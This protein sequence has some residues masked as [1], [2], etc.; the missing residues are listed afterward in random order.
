MNILI[1][2]GSTTNKG[3]YLMLLAA[4]KLG[5]TYFE[6]ANF[7]LPSSVTD[8]EDLKKEGFKF[9]NHPLFHVGH[10][11]WFK[12]GMKYPLFTNLLFKYG[13][14]QSLSGNVKLKDINLVL[15]VSGFAFGDKF[16]KMPLNNLNT[17][18]AFFKEKRIPYVML[19]QA[20]GPFSGDLKKIAKEAFQDADLIF[21]RDN[22][23][24]QN[25]KSLN[26][27]SNK[28]KQASDIT[29]S[30]NT[31][32]KLP[33]RFS[34][35]KPFCSI[36]PNVRMLDK[37]DESWKNNY[38]RAIKNAV[39]TILNNSDFNVLILVHSTT[40]GGDATLA[41]QI[42]ANF[43]DNKRV[44]LDT[45]ENPLVLKKILKDSELLIGSRFHALA[46]ALSSSTPSIATSWLHKYEMLFADYNIKNYSYNKYNETFE[47][48]ILQLL[49][50]NELA[51]VKE[52]LV[53]KNKEIKIANKNLWQLVA[54]TV[55]S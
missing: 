9:L 43:K 14:G 30:L 3:A 38:E 12:L 39:D 54:D 23:S 32:E 50:K 22:I 44:K 40:I 21:A 45:D 15:D 47:Q 6:K 20:L 34:S 31:E 46:S 4:K 5:T 11:R 52:K 36:V 24:Y 7:V 28:C 19:P 10:D 49:N 48:G 41:E 8:K 18:I 26:L 2:G 1:V 27:P 53:T 16:G 55:M 25:L 29:L 51:Q 17:Q 35:F 33:I 42:Y 13:K 37:A